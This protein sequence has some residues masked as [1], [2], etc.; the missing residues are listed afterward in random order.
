MGLQPRNSVG[1]ITEAPSQILKKPY[2]WCFYWIISKYTHHLG[3]QGPIPKVS[4]TVTL[5]GSWSGLNPRTSWL[6]EFMVCWYSTLWKLD[7]CFSFNL[8]CIKRFP[9]DFTLTPTALLSHISSHHGRPVG[10]S[11]KRTLIPHYGNCFSFSWE[12]CKVYRLLTIACCS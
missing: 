2:G 8:N 3:H 5:R 9:K 12:S 6:E 1:T 10:G 4:I 7:Y 11:L